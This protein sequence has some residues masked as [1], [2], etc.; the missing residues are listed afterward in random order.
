MGSRVM[1]LAA[2][3]PRFQVVAGLEP[4]SRPSQAMRRADLLIDFTVPEA[5]VALLGLAARAGIAAV[6]G[7]T[8]FSPSQL[9]RIRGCSRRIPVLLAPNMSRGMA[10]LMALVREAAR[11]LGDFDAAVSETHHR[12]KRDAP[13]G[14]AL[15]LAD[16]AGKVLGRRVPAVSQRV[17]DV[18]GDHSLTLAGPFERIELTHRAHSRDVFARGALEAAL[19]L[20]RRGPGLYG[21]EDL[22]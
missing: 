19:R 8:G 16:A 5:S 17:G 11:R 14:T 7:T 9:K 10:V 6:V 13:S 12:R 22:G 2:A 20:A 18:I 1:A 15:A 21:M 3:D 4:G